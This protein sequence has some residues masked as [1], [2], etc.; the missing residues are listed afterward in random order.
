[1]LRDRSRSR[2]VYPG[3]VASATEPATDFH[4]EAW[5][6]APL[7]A[8]PQYHVECLLGKG[9][10][11][12]V[13]KAHVNSRIVA[14][15]SVRFQDGGR[16]VQVLRELRGC[17][18]IVT[19]LGLFV[20]GVAGS[21]GHGQSLNLVLEYMPDTLQ[22]IVRHH[23]Y[24]GLSVHM[25]HVRLYS[26][27][28]LRGLASL[29]RKGIVHRDFKP[30]NLLVHPRSM[31]LKI[32]DFGTSKMPGEDE[33]ASVYLCSRF[34]RAPE[35]ILSSESTHAVDLWSAGCIVVELIRGQVLFQGK[36]GA[37]QLSCIAEICG[38]PTPAEL[39]A[40]NKFY[41][42]AVGFGPRVEPVPWYQVLG[43]RAPPEAAALVQRLLQYDPSKRPMPLMAMAWEFFDTLRR[44]AANHDPSLFQFLPEE[45]DGLP[46]NIRERLL[47]VAAGHPG[48][49]QH[50][51]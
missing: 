39:H 49:A 31:V 1:M 13:W 16:E 37:D 9:S 3:I 50:V 44:D 51:R 11:G 23:R 42:A 5:S 47:A 19:M 28:L 38:T 22:R 4:H 33:P 30:A 35:L 2:D 36:D 43:P 24:K 8:A 20:S 10:F 29:F 26:Y 21:D 17:P 14:I 40:M 6:L 18:N 25:M 34:Y 45:L 12:A 27:Q 41:D 46:L 32:C 48:G 7:P 15:K